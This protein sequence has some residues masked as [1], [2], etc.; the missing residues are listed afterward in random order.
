MSK[1]KFLNF[2]FEY[3]VGSIIYK[4]ENGKILFLLLHYVSGH[5]DFVKGK[6]E[7]GESDL[8]TLKREAFEET[9]ITDLRVVTNF[10]KCSYYFYKAKGSERKKRI[11]EGK[12]INIFKKVAFYLAETP[13]GKIDIEKINKSHECQGYT[14]I[15][16]DK[17]IKRV[18]HS[19]HEKMLKEAMNRLQ[20][21]GL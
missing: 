13:S 4:R 18:T 21:A 17:A 11:K 12:G 3:S 5:W 16:Y 8:Q 19:R 10:K 2:S 6:K 15:E 20:K 9:G 7:E 1:I 14:W